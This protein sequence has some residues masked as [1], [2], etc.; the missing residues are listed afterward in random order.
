MWLPTKE[1][2]ELRFTNE[3]L[4]WDKTGLIARRICK[5]LPSLKLENAGSGTANLTDE[6]N[7]IRVRFGHS[8]LNLQQDTE[9]TPTVKLFD[10]AN[11]I[12]AFVL[13]EM[14]VSDAT[15]RK[16]GVV[17]SRAILEVR[18]RV[19]ETYYAQ[20]YLLLVEAQ[21]GRYLPLY[22]QQYGPAIRTAK[23]TVAE[24]ATRKAR[25][26]VRVDIAGTG[27]FWTLDEILIR[28][29]DRGRLQLSTSRLH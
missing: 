10:V 9:P 19:R 25:L 23:L 6:E 5:L 13:K 27:G 20:I 7:Q 29:D 16:I 2:L 11:E 14:E 26:Q 8:V 21:P 17:G 18:V 12:V 1:I 4:Y 3:F 24:F 28:T 15:V 22:G